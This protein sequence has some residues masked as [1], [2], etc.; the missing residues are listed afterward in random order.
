MYVVAVL[1]YSYCPKKTQNYFKMD[2]LYHETA[3]KMEIGNKSTK[4]KMH[5][6]QA[7]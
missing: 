4:I 2:Q 6:Q 7:L 5:R 3:I 1:E